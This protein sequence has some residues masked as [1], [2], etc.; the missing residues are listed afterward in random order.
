MFIKDNNITYSRLNGATN[1][2]LYAKVHLSFVPVTNLGAILLNTI[3]DT[4]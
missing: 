2:T 1:Y 3:I 4:I